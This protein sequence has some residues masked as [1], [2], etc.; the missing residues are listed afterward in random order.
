MSKKNNTTQSQHENEPISGVIG[1]DQRND[2]K[3]RPI[4]LEPSLNS[5]LESWTSQGDSGR[6]IVGGKFKKGKSLLT[7]GMLLKVIYEE[8][9]R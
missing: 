2:S 3:G 8:Q 4:P 9:Y 7:A 5:I 1:S 6:T